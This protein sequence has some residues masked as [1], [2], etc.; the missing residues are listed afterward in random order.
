MSLEKLEGDGVVQDPLTLKMD[1]PR[2]SSIAGPQAQEK[3]Q[4]EGQTFCRKEI[5]EKQ[6]G[7]GPDTTE[8]GK[9]ARN[10]TSQ[11][12]VLWKHFT[13]ITAERAPWIGKAGVS[14]DSSKWS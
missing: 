4:G 14:H 13:E 1:P 2:H 5:I 12:A 11:A 8:E 7:E 9:I 10:F 3:L 6:E